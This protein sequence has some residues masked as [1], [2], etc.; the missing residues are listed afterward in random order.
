MKKV[1]LIILVVAVFI[2]LS[3]CAAGPNQMKNMENDEGEIAGFWNGLW[4]GIITPFAFIISLFTDTVNVYES[5]NTGGWYNLGFI[6]GL[7]IIFGGSGGGAGR[8]G[9]RG[10]KHS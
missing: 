5:Y 9:R 10:R 8:R 1:F 3:A 7:M 2:T 4:H 6:F